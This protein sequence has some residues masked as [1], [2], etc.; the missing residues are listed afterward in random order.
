[1]Y[2]TYL[3]LAFC[4]A[5]AGIAAGYFWQKHFITASSGLIS[6]V[7]LLF[8]AF[9]V[10]P[11]SSALPP[12]LQSIWFIPHV[13]AYFCGYALILLACIASLRAIFSKQQ[14][15]EMFQIT[16]QLATLAL[17][18]ITCGLCFGSIWANDAWGSWWNWDPKENLALVQWLLLAAFIHTPLQS[19]YSV[20]GVTLLILTLLITVLM[21]LGITFLPLTGSSSHV[22]V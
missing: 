2:E 13:L 6:A 3:L 1:L 7:I 4:V 11:P 22:N 12:F 18:F 17:V 9:N 16:G 20:T 8:A 14:Q 15:Q 19:R 5:G 10:S 21:Y